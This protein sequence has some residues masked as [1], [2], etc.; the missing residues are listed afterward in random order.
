MAVTTLVLGLFML[1]ASSYP[2][3]LTPSHLPN[4]QDLANGERANYEQN[5]QDAMAVFPKLQT[6]LDVN[7][8]FNRYEVYCM[9]EMRRRG[10]EE[11]GE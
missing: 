6:G 3:T 9:G 7:V 10:E 2:Q 11:D 1:Y 5:V 4:L 8:K